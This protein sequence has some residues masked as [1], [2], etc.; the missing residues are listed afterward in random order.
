LDPQNEMFQ[1]LIE[2][3]YQIRV[4]SAEHIPQLQ[5]E[6]E[7]R[8]QQGELNKEFYQSR[9][10][11]FDFKPPE[12]L[13]RV[14]SLIVTALPRPQTQATFTW[15][16]RRRTLSVPPTYTDYD[17]ITQK[18][19]DNLAMIVKPMGYQVANSSLPLKL[20]AAWSGLAQ[21]GRNNICYVPNMGSYLQLAA[22]YSDIPCQ[23]DSWQEPSMM[24]ACKSCERCREACPTGAIPSDRFLL[25]AE[26]CIVFHNER[27]GNI[28]F[29]S[30]MARS[31]HNCI[32][33]CLHCQRACPIDKNFVQWTGKREEF[34]EQ[35][36]NLI[37]KG[38]TAEEL[39]EETI[40][41]LKHL[42]LDGYLGML[43]RNLG[44]F[45][46][47]QDALAGIKK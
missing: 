13:R 12:K 31:W 7:N 30:W 3:G 44:V 35:E 28:P 19:A 41:K 39:P 45:F 18:I 15:K 25:Y 10:S 9:L 1:Y 34:S 43:P 42:S 4:V 24:A 27:P 23:N 46:G 5:S 14:K 32:V 2:Q 20:L 22:V 33:G 47:E 40:S 37:L 36:T 26:R 8:L 6:M 16:G 29:P 11:W 21:Y 17:M 38:I